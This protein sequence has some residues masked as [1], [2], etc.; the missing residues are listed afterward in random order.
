MKAAAQVEFLQTGMLD[1]AIVGL[2]NCPWVLAA[3]TAIESSVTLRAFPAPVSES[4]APH[5]G[6]P[7][8]SPTRALYSRI[9]LAKHNRK[10]AAGNYFPIL[11]DWLKEQL[12]F[13]CK[14]SV[15]VVLN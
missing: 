1:L 12:S 10:L 7:P 11:D 4:R 9:A 14:L 13:N 3:G 15:L 6:S 5:Q 8:D 2:R